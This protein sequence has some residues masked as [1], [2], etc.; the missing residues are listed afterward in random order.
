MKKLHRLLPSLR[1]PTKTF[2]PPCLFYVLLHTH[3]PPPHTHTHTLSIPADHVLDLLF[4]HCM[5]LL[6]SFLSAISFSSPIF[7]IL[8]PSPELHFSRSHYHFSFFT[9]FP[10][11]LPVF[12]YHFS[13]LPSHFFLSPLLC[14]SSS[15]PQN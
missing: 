11:A 4:L 10:L 15:Q 6:P 8:T 12:S 14:V 13:C 9:P 5:F 1:P 7:F 2:F 3:P